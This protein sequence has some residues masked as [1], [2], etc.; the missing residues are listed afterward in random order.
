MPSAAVIVSDGADFGKPV[1]MDAL[2][3]PRLA[4]SE[5]LGLGAGPSLRHHFGEL[6]IILHFAAAHGDRTVPMPV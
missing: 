3:S 6:V 2:E 1:A 4:A 5:R